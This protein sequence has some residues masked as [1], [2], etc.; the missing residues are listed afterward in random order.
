[1]N[2][3]ICNLFLERKNN[4]Q[5]NTSYPLN[6]KDWEMYRMKGEL[7]YSACNKLSFYIHIPFCQHICRFCEYTRIHVPDSLM[8]QRYLSVIANDIEKFLNSYPTV[9]LSGFDIGGGTPTSLDEKN[10]QTLLDIYLSTKTRVSVT[11]DY[12][13]SIEATFQTLTS[14]KVRLIKKAGINRISLGVQSSAYN[15]QKNVGRV[16]LDI[17]MMAKVIEQIHANGIEKINIDL[18]YGLKGQTI[19][20]IEKDLELIKRLSPEQVTLYELRTNLNHE[21]MM[22][23]KEQLYVFYQ[24]LYDGLINLGYLAHFG[25]NTFSRN[26]SDKGLSSYLRHRMLDFLPYKGFGLSAQ[27]M[28]DSGISYNI[29]KL[30][31]RLWKALD[32]KS[33]QSKDTYALPKYEMLSKYIAISA[34]YGQFNI[35]LANRILGSNI[36]E[37][38]YNEID[39]CLSKGY[40]AVDNDTIRITPRGFKYYGAVFSLFYYD[41]NRSHTVSSKIQHII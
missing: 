21:K 20:D 35:L 23:S 25:Q 4:S 28:S 30:Q 17:K 34:Y 18:M 37:Y 14:N 27:S 12:E 33:F 39:F 11:D 40:I 7:D 10:F 15:V 22:A 41:S 16:N 36:L 19:N 2:D 9:S 8:Q 13:P 38:F 1:M 26:C 24:T 5:F 31:T 32:C 6:S 3:S 29:G